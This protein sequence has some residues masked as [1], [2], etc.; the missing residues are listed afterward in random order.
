MAHV[1]K[2]ILA[3]GLLILLHGCT[4]TAVRRSLNKN[5][6]SGP[7]ATKDLAVYEPWFG[8]PEHIE[9]GYSAQD[10]VVVRKQIDEAKRMGIS[11]FVV[12]WYGYREPF[13]DRSYALLQSTAAEK[14][15]K[16]AMLYDET[17]EDNGHVTEDTLADFDRFH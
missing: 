11:G 7:Q 17:E 6:P 16:V 2:G 3:V 1:Y 9:V 4:Q 5:L 14:D 13:E 8:T 10:P 12:D 15:F